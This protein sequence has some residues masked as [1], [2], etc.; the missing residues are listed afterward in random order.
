MKLNVCFFNE[1]Q[2]LTLL[3]FSMNN[4]SI[5]V[6]QHFNYLYIMLDDNVAWRRK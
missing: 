2:H 1:C 6:M 3:Q 4:R 5:D